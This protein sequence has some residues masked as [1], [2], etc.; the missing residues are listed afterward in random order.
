MTPPAVGRLGAGLARRGVPPRSTE[1]SLGAGQTQA[2]L[3]AR[4]RPDT[5]AFAECELRVGRA[6]SVVGAGVDSG[7]RVAGVCA[8]APA[9]DPRGAVGAPQARGLARAGT[10][11][12]A[13]AAHVQGQTARARAT[14][15]VRDAVGQAHP[16]GAGPRCA[17]FG[18][19]AGRAGGAGSS[20]D[21]VAASGGVGDAPLP[22]R[23]RRGRVA[24]GCAQPQATAG[25][26]VLVERAGGGVH[27]VEAAHAVNASP[28]G[29]GRRVC[30]GRP[31]D[32]ERRIHHR[33]VG[34]RRVGGVRRPRRGIEPAFAGARAP[35]RARVTGAERGDA[36]A[37]EQAAQGL[38]KAGGTTEHASVLSRAAPMEQAT[39]TLPTGAAR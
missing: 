11:L 39:M 22:R 14:V 35:A 25:D 23:A 28:L 5:R 15:G 32:S 10:D 4:L 12:R 6:V 20:S 17:V 29:A 7:R 13:H 19:I 9:T 3:S 27:A 37:D 8:A 18:R 16:L 2:P 21:A 34:G 24:R 33:D 36:E 30:A 38:G 1:A 26:A 31:R